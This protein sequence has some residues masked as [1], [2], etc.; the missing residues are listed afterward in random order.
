MTSIKIELTNS[1]WRECRNLSMA[2]YD[3]GSREHPYYAGDLPPLFGS[4][5]VLPNDQSFFVHVVIAN[6]A[7][8][9][10]CPDNFTTQ[11]SGNSST[12][13]A[14]GVIQSQGAAQQRD[15]DFH[16]LAQGSHI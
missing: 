1:L 15:G 3:P 5:F 16:R 8:T 12:K 10:D 6:T 7:I 14:C 9:H 2:H 11:P 4:R 13:I